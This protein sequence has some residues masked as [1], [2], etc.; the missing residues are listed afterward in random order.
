[1]SVLIKPII[2]EKATAL[3]ELRNTYTFLV[4]PSSNKLQIKESVEK[5]YGVQVEGVRTMIYAPKIS[6][7]HTK[8]GFQVG[9]SNKLK[10]AVVLVK[11]G[12]VIDV[13]G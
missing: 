12:D 3:A 9:K 11:E 10:K 8:K 13:L 7:K 2:S 6:T 1:M 4:Q 5:I